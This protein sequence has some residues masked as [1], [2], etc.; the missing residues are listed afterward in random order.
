MNELERRLRDL[1]AEAF[2]PESGDVSARVDERLRS[3]ATRAGRTP[4]RLH[5]GH[6]ALAAAALALLVA[7]AVLTASPDARSAVLR[8][9]GLEGARIER[10]QPD[11]PAARQDAPLRLGQRVTFSEARRRAGF[12]VGVP[13]LA[14]LGP[15]E[16]VF[17][18]GA[19]GAVSFTWAARRGLTSPRA[20]RDPALV[21]TQLEGTVTPLIQ[22]A[23]G[24]G[25]VIEKVRVAGEPGYWLQGARHEFAYVRPD[26]GILQETTRL[27][28]N[29][30]LWERDGHLLRLEGARS[31]PAALAIAR[32]VR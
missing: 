25:T 32:S 17:V 4:A 28:G 3:L 7:A 2:F 13:R 15:P 20:G 1:P 22:K 21:M 27:A 6:P 24:P 18:D 11:V 9:F 30:L 10:R 29:T 12:P 31:K 14:R 16:A 19:L 26:G 23:A 8:F 5:V